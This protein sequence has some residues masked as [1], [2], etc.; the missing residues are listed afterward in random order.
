MSNEKATIYDFSRM[1]ENVDYCVNCPMNVLGTSHNDCRRALSVEPDK[2]NK[3]ILKWCKEHPVKTRQD[4]FLEM[5]PNADVSL[6][7]LDICP[8]K[9]MGADW[10][11]EP[12]CSYAVSQIRQIEICEECQKSYW[13]AEV[14]ENE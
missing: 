14:E 5:F 10:S 4:K 13:L 6:G 9:V 7:Y 8:K 3:I 11:S 2:S 1:C 12:N